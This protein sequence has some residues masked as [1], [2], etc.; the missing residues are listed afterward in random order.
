MLRRLDVPVESPH[1]VVLSPERLGAGY[2]AP[3]RPLLGIALQSVA[4]SLQLLQSE[5]P[6]GSQ[7]YAQVGGRWGHFR[8]QIRGS[9]A[10]TLCGGPVGQFQLAAGEREAEIH[11]HVGDR[12]VRDLPALA[13]A[14][15]AARLQPRGL[16]TRR[17][18]MREE[19]PVERAEAQGALQ[20]L[21]PTPEL[22]QGEV[23][24]QQCGERVRG[25]L[26]GAQHVERVE[27]IALPA[28]P[29][30]VVLQTHARQQREV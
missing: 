1:P 25:Q 22:A 18:A 5:A 11:L 27:A 23:V 24:L 26:Q 28:V 17:A 20:A 4:G 21:A 8:V 15:L 9:R 13:G 16:H 3:L 10:L 29:V 12:A 7:R 19:G 2:S 30:D 6:G 14:Q